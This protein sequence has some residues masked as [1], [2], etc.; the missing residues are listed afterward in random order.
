MNEEIKKRI[1]EL[2]NQ[3]LTIYYI[4]KE[5]NIHSWTAQQVIE[6]ELKK[7]S[8]SLFKGGEI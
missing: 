3:G 2:H 7:D 4:A 1:M 8:D 6:E 5:L